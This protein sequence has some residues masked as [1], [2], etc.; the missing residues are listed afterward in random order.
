MAIF[1]FG[2]DGVLEK[3]KVACDFREYHEWQERLRHNMDDFRLGALK[4]VVLGA[5]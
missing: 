4:N 5:S 1:F 2:T 3:V